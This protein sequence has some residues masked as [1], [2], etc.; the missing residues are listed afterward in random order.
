MVYNAGTVD[1]IILMEEGFKKF[2][3]NSQKKSEG[4]TH[5]NLFSWA[6]TKVMQPCQAATF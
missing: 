6:V 3:K 5:P 2:K 1:H 4:G